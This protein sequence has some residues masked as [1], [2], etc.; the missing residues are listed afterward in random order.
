[1]IHLLSPEAGTLLAIVL[2]LGGI[3]WL[4][5]AGTKSIWRS[6]HNS[7]PRYSGCNVSL[8]D[9]GKFWKLFYSGQNNHIELSQVPHCSARNSVLSLTYDH[10]EFEALIR[11]K[12][13]DGST[14]LR[15]EKVKASTIKQLT[16]IIEERFKTWD[17]TDGLLF[18]WDD[19]YIN[20]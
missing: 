7:A 5:V 4:F 13:Y 20:L 12:D 19:F 6:L 18:L 16:D 15:E 9:D 2:L 1:M 11:C 10:K 8:S 17:S 3:A 14:V